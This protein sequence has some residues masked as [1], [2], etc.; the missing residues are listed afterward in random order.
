MTEYDEEING[1][2]GTRGFSSFLNSQLGCSQ[3]LLRKKSKFLKDPRKS[4][5]L[6]ETLSRIGYLYYQKGS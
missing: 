1:M 4:A 6:F 3:D 2:H 5:E